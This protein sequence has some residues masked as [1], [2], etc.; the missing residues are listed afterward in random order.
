MSKASVGFSV[1][2][3]L[4]A[5]GSVVAA[6]RE[7]ELVSSAP[8]TGASLIQESNTYGIV[9]T[10]IVK[11]GGIVGTGIVKPGGIVGTGIVKPG[12]IVGTGIVKPGGIVGTGL[13]KPGG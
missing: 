8:V 5:A 13:T 2:A 6:D 1:I 12:G 3:S 9:G 7:S 10:G 11:P 4:L